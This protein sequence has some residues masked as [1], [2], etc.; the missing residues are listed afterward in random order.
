MLFTERVSPLGVPIRP[1]WHYALFSLAAV[2]DD[3]KGR[4]THVE[5]IDT[6]DTTTD[7]ACADCDVFCI[8]ARG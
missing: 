4:K 6:V 1:A 7:A 3:R 5:T 2:R 8:V